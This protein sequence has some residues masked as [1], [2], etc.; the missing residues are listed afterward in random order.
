MPTVGTVSDVN[1]GGECLRSLV[2]LGSFGAWAVGSANTHARTRT[3]TYSH[4]HSH[5]NHT[6]THIHTQRYTVSHMY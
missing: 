3:H 5:T 2:L 6:H 1:L 4:T